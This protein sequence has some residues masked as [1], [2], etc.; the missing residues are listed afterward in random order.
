MENQIEKA[1]TFKGN[2]DSLCENKL[3]EKHFT[4]PMTPRDMANLESEICDKNNKLIELREAKKAFDANIG[5]QIKGVESE[6]ANRLEWRDDG[7]MP[8][9]GQ[10]YAVPNYVTNKMEYY[11]SVDYFL[12]E[13]RDLYE[14]EYQNNLEF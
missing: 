8:V 6:I 3:V 7:K 1:K 13:S 2:Y 4:K 11:D 12:V 5:G 10:C 9:D 14:S